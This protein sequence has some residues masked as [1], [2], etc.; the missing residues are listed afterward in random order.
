MTSGAIQYG[1][2][3]TVRRF[4]IVSVSCAEMPKSPEYS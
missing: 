3:M 4:M 1:E 2:P